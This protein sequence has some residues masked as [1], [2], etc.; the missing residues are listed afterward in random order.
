MKP[1]RRFRAVCSASLA[2]ALLVSAGCGMLAQPA[3]AQAGKIGLTANSA[4]GRIPAGPAG[5]SIRLGQ[6]I[7]Q[8][9]PHYAARYTGNQM[10]CADCHL[11]G[12][13]APYSAPMVGLTHIFPT[14]NQR[15]GRVITLAERIQQCFVRSENGRPL[16]AESREMTALLAYI[17][18]LSPAETAGRAHPGR[19]LVKL[20]SLR[21]DPG[22]G[23]TIYQKQCAVCH[24]D[25][26]AG[27]PPVLPPLWGAASFNNGAGMSTVEK[28]AAFVQYNMPQNAP[29]SLSPQEAYDVAAYVNSKPRPKMNPTY[30]KY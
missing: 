19:G 20:P 23:A 11:L 7:F 10:N 5:D 15:A 30:A 14:Y 1:G 4:P 25:D 22:R 17:A 18:W 28:M 9:T 6:L 16:S 21:G 12:G 27:V 2:A 24:G 29:G 26:G 3:A 8:Q 13:R